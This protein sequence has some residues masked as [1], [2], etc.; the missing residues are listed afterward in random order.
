MKQRNPL[1]YFAPCLITIIY[2]FCIPLW[3]NGNV[4][5]EIITT[6][7][8]GTVTII[9]A[10]IAFAGS[11]KSGNNVTKEAKSDLKLEHK[12]LKSTLQSDISK[13]QNTIEGKIN[14]VKEIINTEIAKSEERKK[15][16][17]PE[18]VTM[19]R[20]AEQINNMHSNWLEANAKI[21]LLEK[22]RIT[23]NKRIAELENENSGLK[24]ALE[25]AQSEY[26][27]MMGKRSMYNDVIIETQDGE[28]EG[29]RDQEN[30]EM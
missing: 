22:E 28:Q 13:S 30:M 26:I 21:N 19:H 27:A 18:Q 8:T 9:V 16:L 17:T 4:N 12:D 3:R 20:V 25:K 10:I 6:I 23:L 14:T 2:G 15:Y 29:N 1:I 7:I 11:C 24:E 5:A